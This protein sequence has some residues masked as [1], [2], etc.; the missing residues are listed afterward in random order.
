MFD[1]PPLTFRTEVESKL[2]VD[3]RARQGASMQKKC[4][5]SGVGGMVKGPHG[6]EAAEPVVR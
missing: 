5:G 6:E 3:G 4:A 1:R 2:S